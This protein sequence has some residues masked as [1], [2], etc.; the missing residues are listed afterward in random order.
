MAIAANKV[1]GVRAALAVNE[2][3]VRLTRDHNDANI[4]TFGAK[5]TSAEEAGKMAGLFI[6]TGFSGGARHLRRIAK[7][8]ELDH[9]AQLQPHEVETTKS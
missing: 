2:E 1:P 4:L 6:E 3:E 8:A 9:A 5:F 7:I